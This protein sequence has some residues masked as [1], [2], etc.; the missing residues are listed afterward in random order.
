MRHAELQLQNEVEEKQKQLL[1]QALLEEEEKVVEERHRKT[2]ERQKARL[3]RKATELEKQRE[4]EK[5]RREKHKRKRKERTKEKEEKEMIDDT[6]K[7]KDYDPDKEPEAKFMVEDQEIDDEDTFEVEKHVHAVNFDEAGEYLMAMNRYMEAFTKI[8][9]RGKEDMAR[10]YKKL[11]K[12]V[13][14]MIEELGAHSPIKAADTD[15][16]FDTIIDPQ[17][18]AWR[19]ALHGMKMGNSKGIL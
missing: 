3:E 6:D 4:C 15:A 14:L 18:I 8:V 11:I 16:V 7:D 12:F 19:G 9:R 10:E 2:E 17:C 1:E 13:K 5:E